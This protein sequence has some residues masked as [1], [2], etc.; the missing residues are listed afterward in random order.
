MA[1][2]LAPRAQGGDAEG[3]I[4]GEFVEQCDFR[5]VECRRPV[6]VDLEDAEALILGEQ[7]HGQRGGKAALPR[8]SAPI[9]APAFSADV[10]Y[11]LGRPYAH[12]T[13]R[14]CLRAARMRP[15][16]LGWSK[17]A[18][19]PCTPDDGVSRCAR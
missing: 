10:A 16:D 19:A 7:R 2:A 6:A 17:R 3:K 12:G 8:L 5:G 4:C 14:R 18:R 11:D 15:I 1:L 13:G 9:R